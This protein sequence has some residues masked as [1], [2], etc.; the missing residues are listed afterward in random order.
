MR[1]WTLRSFTIRK[2]HLSAAEQAAQKK[3]KEPWSRQRSSEDEEDEDDEE[4]IDTKKLS[5]I[6][7]ARLA[8]I[9][10]LYPDAD[11]IN[12]GLKAEM[13]LDI[14]LDHYDFCSDER[15]IQPVERDASAF[16]KARDKA[17]KAARIVRAKSIKLR[18]AMSHIKDHLE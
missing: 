17:R 1:S 11:Y 7:F 3:T 16:E 6:L 8:C 12:R 14:E 15:R 2:D 10:N 9:S 5:Q 13:K 18:E 4:P